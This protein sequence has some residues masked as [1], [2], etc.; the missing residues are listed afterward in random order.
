MT[1]HTDEVVKV[2]KAAGSPSSARD[3]AA[4][5]A[6]DAA[7]KSAIETAKRKAKNPDNTNHD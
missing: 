2:A 5:A 3:A 6:K 1:K 7:E 4:A